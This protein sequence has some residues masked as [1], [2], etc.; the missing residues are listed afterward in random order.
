MHSQSAIQVCIF[1]ESRC[2]LA[3][4]AAAAAARHER[5][6]QQVR[7]SRPQSR[8]A[9]RLREGC[10]GRHRLALRPALRTIAVVSTVVGK[11]EPNFGDLDMAAGWGHAGKGGVTMP[12]KGKVLAREYTPEERATFSE[13]A[14]ALGI[15]INDLTALLGATTF[16][17]H[18]NAK[19]Y[20]KNIPCAVWEYTLGGYQVIKK[21]L[22]Y[23]EKELLG[24]SITKEEAR[25]VTDVARR[26]AALLLMGPA[27]DANYEAVKSNTYPWR[28]TL[29]M[30]FDLD[31]MPN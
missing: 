20:W 8:R 24:R 30:G 18:L 6:T 15:S 31:L 27:L 13:G 4:L 2:A 19:V 28:P 16:D 10:L 17:V 25:H 23:R 14:E 12:A 22:S 7:G 5:P 11:L 21:W 26:I 29:H 1:R 3:R 9:A